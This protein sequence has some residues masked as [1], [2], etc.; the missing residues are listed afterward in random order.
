MHT[1]SRSASPASL[2]VTLCLSAALAPR[3][4]GALQPLSTFV[5]SA[6]SVNPDNRVSHATLAQRDAEVDVA[7]GRYLPSFTATGTYTRNEYEVSFSGVA[8]GFPGNLV[9][10]PLNQLD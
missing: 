8:F 3:T 7:V 1:H 10:Q 9:I 4:A 6:R 5:Q 2:I